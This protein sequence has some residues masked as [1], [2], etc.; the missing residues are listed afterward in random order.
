M[1]GKHVVSTHA[2][3]YQCTIWLDT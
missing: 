2:K 3:G 1:K